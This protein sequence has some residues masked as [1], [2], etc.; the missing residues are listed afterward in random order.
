MAEG[1]AAKHRPERVACE[2]PTPPKF[3]AGT[4]VFLKNSC[5]SLPTIGEP[6]KRAK[7]RA[8]DQCCGKG[9]PRRLCGYAAGDPGRTEFGRTSVGRPPIRHPT[10]KL[11]SYDERRV[12]PKNLCKKPPFRSPA[13]V[14]AELRRVP[15]VRT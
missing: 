15:I 3:G 1:P 12:V 14:N 2:C 6:K 13:H 9:N 8:T 4:G 11:S 10:L 7:L 5:G